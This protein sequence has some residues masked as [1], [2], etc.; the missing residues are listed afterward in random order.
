[1]RSPASIINSKIKIKPYLSRLRYFCRAF[2]GKK[3][4]KILEP[5]NGGIGIKLKIIKIK[6]M[7]IIVLIKKTKVKL[8]NGTNLK[9]K[10]KI[11][12]QSDY[13]KDQLELP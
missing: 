5:S 3:A 7:V 13:P 1:M 12:L 11:W 2:A 6:L 4:A 8:L 10:P 9:N